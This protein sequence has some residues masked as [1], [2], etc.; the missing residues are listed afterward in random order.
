MFPVNLMY[1]KYL[2][3]FIVG[4]I[5]F[6][7]L[8]PGTL[9]IIHRIEKISDQTIPNISISPVTKAAINNYS[10]L[11]M[12]LHEIASYS[13]E[14]PFLDHFKSSKK[15]MTQCL[16]RDPECHDQWNTQEYD[17]LNLDENGWV[18]SLPA[19]SDPPQYTSVS[20]VLFK[21]MPNL[22]PGGRYLVI[23]EGDGTI[24][25]SQ[26]AKKID[27]ES[28]P[29][30]DIIVVDPAKSS[31]ILITITATDPKKTGNYIRNIRVIQAD[32]ENLYQKGELFNPLFINKLKK[33]RALRFMDWMQTNKSI[34]KDWIDRPKPKFA[35]Y[36]VKGVP[37][38]I[39]IALCN[40]IQADPWFNIPHQATDEYIIKFSQ[41]VKEKLN[42]NLKVYLEFSNEVWNWKFPQANYALAQGQARWGQE[43]KESY[44]QWYGMR[45]AQMCDIWKGTFAEIKERVM[46]VISTQSNVEGREGK[47][48]DC[49]YWVAEG[50]QPC[51]RHGIDAYAITGYFNGN[52]DRPENSSLVLSWLADSDAGVGKAFEQLRESVHSN[53]QKFIYHQKIAKKKGLQLVVYEGG[54]H[55]VGRNSVKEN[56][57][58][59]QFFIELNRQPEMYK[60]YTDLLGNWQKAGGTLFMHF[61]DIRRPNKHGSWG[62]LEYVAQKG[63]P[64]YN[65]LIDFIDHHPCWWKGC[66]KSSGAKSSINNY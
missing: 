40:K 22:Y 52:F 43:K 13:T 47:I 61:V 35:S 18:K 16:K 33:F 12:G 4:I 36:T 2:A 46:C 25:Y 9:R 65:A 56:E 10:P 48:L 62:A 38:E 8:I 29:G 21:D 17:L 58:L 59:T 34:Q 23:Y 42:P 51:Y 45:T 27:T 32:Q 19:A 11:G 28:T 57:I 6:L 15:W 55:I 49:P 39:M 26:A 24:T 14:L 7:I 63:S 37:L 60:L 53:Y 66:S 64:K 20:T 30:R 54:Q 41:M 44:L 5:V 50:N 3:I 31:G 1:R